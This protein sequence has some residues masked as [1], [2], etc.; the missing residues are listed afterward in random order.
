MKRKI[1]IYLVVTLMLFGFM[2]NL[3]AQSPP[4]LDD[5]WELLPTMSDNFSGSVINVGLWNKIPALNGNTGQGCGW[6]AGGIHVS[7]HVSVNNGYLKLKVSKAYN[8]YYYDGQI[9][10]KNSNYTYGYF[11]ISAKL[12][13]PGSFNT[14]NTPCANGL[15]PS[16]WL[17]WIDWGQ[18]PCYH[19]EVDIVE[20]LYKECEDTKSMGGGMWD[21][22]NESTDP[23]ATN[24][25]QVKRVAFNTTNSTALFE[26][27]HKYGLEW[28]ENKLIWYLDDEIVY[29][30]TGEGIPTHSMFVVLS[31]QVHNNYVDAN[32]LFPQEFKVNYFNYYQLKQ[33]CK[34]DSY[35]TSNFD[36]SNFNFA[37][38][39]NIIFNPVNSINMNVGDVKTFRA[40]NQII[41]NGDFIVP[42]GS[43]L[44]LIPTPCK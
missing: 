44:N 41:I 20:K 14:N 19:D 8:N 7:N 42:L 37:V 3:N 18:F 39:R 43:E 6:G 15:W 21:R 16:F 10:T 25:S 29:S 28:F 9:Q 2:M 23:N 5:N 13:Y 35:I 1:K 33:D 4:D 36:F 24:C 27:E 12:L 38:K 17:Y 30:Y 31:M 40:S 32:T 11:E 34:S 26:Q 22:Y